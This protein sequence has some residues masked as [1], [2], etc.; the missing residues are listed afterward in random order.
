MIHQ[1]KSEVI[2]RFNQNLLSLQ[3][4]ISNIRN[5]ETKAIST[6][7]QQTQSNL[8]KQADKISCALKEFEQVLAGLKDS[9]SS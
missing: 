8:P 1:L 7:I 5:H 4:E 9:M 6:L 2:D 3:N